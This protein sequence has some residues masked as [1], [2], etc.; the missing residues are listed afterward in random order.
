MLKRC[1][2]ILLL[3]VAS[4]L[5]GQQATETNPLAPSIE[6]SD[7][8]PVDGDTVE[9]AAQRSRSITDHAGTVEYFVRRLHPYEPI[10]FV[11]GTERP[12]GKFQFSLR[13]QIFQG[14]DVPDGVFAPL[15]GLSF[16][17]SQTSLW[18]LEA[19][20]KPFVDNSYRPEAM[21]HYDDLINPKRL[22]VISRLG[23]QAGYQHESN[24]LNELESRSVNYLYVRPIITFGSRD[25]G[26]GFI[27]VA[28]RL[29]AYVG[30]LAENPDIKKYRGYGD[31]RLIV[32]QGGGLQAAFTGRLGSD[33]RKGSIQLDLTYPL[34][35]LIRGSAD[36]YLTAQVFNGYGEGMI[37]Y[38][39]NDTTLRLG[40]SLIR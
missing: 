34:S 9:R 36:V 23:L 25:E 6:L 13:Y 29:H 14:P 33:L 38:D 31:L 30:G 15:A 35:R 24:G 19:P 12:S 11:A 37:A 21:L 16:A 22:R 32:G 10:Y 26:S 20:S 5:F 4:P 3:S 2:C 40:V 8:P 18:D 7:A 39:E 1:W 28:P 27:M 17:Y